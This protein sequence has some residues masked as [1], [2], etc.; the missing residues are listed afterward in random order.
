MLYKIFKTLVEDGSSA[1]S[2]V[3]RAISSNLHTRYQENE[4]HMLLNKASL[5]D[6]QL[7]SI[8]YLD[9]EERTCT[10]DSL[11]NETVA[12]FSPAVNEETVILDDSLNSHSTTATEITQSSESNNETGRK[13]CMLKKLLRIS[14]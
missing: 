9:K 6:P 8:M 10:I 5:L 11:V 3:N 13:K 2:A 7:K 12:K 14:F 4:I 1:I